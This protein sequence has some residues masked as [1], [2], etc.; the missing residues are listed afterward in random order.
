VKPHTHGIH[1]DLN[2][3]LGHPLYPLGEAVQ[4]LQEEL[5]LLMEEWNELAA[6]TR[7]IYRRRHSRF[8]GDE[9][10]WLL[11]KT[12]PFREDVREHAAWAEEQLRPL[13][14]RVIGDASGR[15][16]DL[17]AMIRRA[18]NRLERFQAGLAA[19]SSDPERVRDIPEALLKTSRAFEGLFRL[20]GEL[21]DELWE[22]TDAG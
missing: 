11:E 14:E 8:V 16:D 22:S 20:E 19:A 10:G 6:L 2:A 15:L 12:G 5:S 3:I 7:S 9:F 13:L 18:E 17:D 4:R 21:L 1:D